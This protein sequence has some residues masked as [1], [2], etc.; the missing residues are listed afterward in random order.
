MREDIGKDKHRVARKKKRG[1][2]VLRRI[3]GKVSFLEVLA[4]FSL[5]ILAAFGSWCYTNQP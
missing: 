2:N 3:Q 5:Y 1:N 4:H